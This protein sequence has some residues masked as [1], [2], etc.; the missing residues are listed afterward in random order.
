EQDA[1]RRANGLWKK[2]LAD[3]QAPGLDPAIDEALEDFIARK[4]ASM[5]DA[6]V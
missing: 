1:A 5:P 4:K 3:Y 6:F 2:M